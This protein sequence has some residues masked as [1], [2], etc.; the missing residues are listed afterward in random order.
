[1]KAELRRFGE[2]K[3]PVVII[4]DYSGSAE[5]VARLADGLAPFEP[6][7]N[8]YPGL[9]R[10]LTP[11]DSAATDYVE[12]TCRTAAQFVA[13]GFNARAFKL[14]EVSF[15]IVTTRPGDLRLP[16][17][18]PHFD[19]VDPDYIALLHYLRVPEGTGTA[20]FRQRSTGIELVTAS[21]LDRFV[22]TAKAET[23]RLPANIGYIQGSNEFFE[24]IGAVEAVPDRMLIY[25]GSMLHSGIIPPDMQFSPDPRVGRL[26]A[27]FFIQAQRQ[28]SHA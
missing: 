18:G 8:F 7:F 9:R 5:A 24:Q 11:E 25:Q 14:L 23:A 20:F 1:M 12:Q 17:R 27:N 22:D 21:N 2:S 19:S 26:T 13:G 16:Q 28:H 10:V 3:S 15:S 6:A 4:D